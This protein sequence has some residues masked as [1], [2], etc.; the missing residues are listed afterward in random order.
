[1]RIILLAVTIFLFFT[2]PETLDFSVMPRKNFGGVFLCVVWVILAVGMIR[3]LFPNKRITMIARKQHNGL[4]HTAPVPENG[5]QADKTAAYKRL[6]RGMF[7]SAVAWISINAVT[8]FVLSL[9]DM[10]TPPTALVL[11]VF[12]A[13][14]DLI[15]VLFFCP[16]QVFFMQN[17][18]CTVC[19]IHNWDCLMMCTPLILFPSVY[20]FSLLLISVV[21]LIRWEIVTRKSRHFFIEDINENLYCVHCEDKMCQLRSNLWRR[22]SARQYSKALKKWGN[23][24]GEEN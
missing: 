17:R 9:L 3:Y 2:E 13:V 22:I 8:F 10:L 14:C 20:S 18:C 7:F 15:C 16:F 23:S 6:N 19:R 24:Y 5:V 11:V 12:Y 21:V 4:S 1:M